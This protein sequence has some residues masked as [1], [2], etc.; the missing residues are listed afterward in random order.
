[1]GD[2]GTPAAMPA[3]AMTYGSVLHRLLDSPTVASKEWVT[4]QYDSMVQTRTVFAPGADAAVLRIHGS[5]KAIAVKLD[6]NG[7]YGYLDPFTGGAIAVAE[8]ARNVACVGARPVAVTDCLNFGSP[9]KAEGFWQ[10]KQSVLGIAEATDAFGIPVVSGNVSFYNETEAGSVFPTPTIGM[11]GILDSVDRRC[12]LAFREEGDIAALL[13]AY[14][15]HSGGLGGS[16]YLSVIHGLERGR[17][18]MVD[19][20]GEKRLQELLVKCI[21]E[22]LLASCHDVSDGG[23]AVCLAE[24]AIS[25]GCGAAILLDRARFHGLPASIAVFGEAQGRAVVTVRTEKQLAA[26]TAAGN[27]SGV[28]VAWIGTVGGD[29]LRIGFGPAVLLDEPVSDLKESFR[30]AIPRRMAAVPQEPLSLTES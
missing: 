21:A 16:E 14:H 9:E 17:P 10:F 26:L 5:E 4:E 20:P 28:Q 12:S 15:D 27:S 19:L 22:G 6:G 8:A 24:C 29:R 23:L 7:R 3:P 11:L 1:E 30:N 2:L 25:G 13:T 18:P